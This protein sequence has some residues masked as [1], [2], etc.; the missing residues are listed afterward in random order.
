MEE[1][2]LGK[3]TDYPKTYCPQILTAVPRALNRDSYGIDNSLFTGFDSWH[4]YEVSFLLDSGMPVAGVLK[5]TYPSDTVCIVESKSLKLY[6]G[7]F[8][9]HKLGT[10]RQAG[11]QLLVECIVTDLSRLLQTEVKASFFLQPPSH[12]PFDFNGY[13]LLEEE[14]AENTR[15]S[16][17]QEHPA[18]LSEETE[19]KGEKKICSHLLKSNCKI[20]GQPDWGSI[21]IRIK[22][23]NLPADQSL[24]RYVVSLR[25]EN[26]FHEEICEMVYKR[27]YDLFHPEILAVTCLYT[28]R[29]GIDICPS[30]A[31]HPEYL[32]S[33]LGQVETLTLQEFRQ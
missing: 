31:N 24:L 28:R 16:I 29:G 20:T 19:G 6:L 27:L 5:I 4:A 11:I 30:R 10:T 17:Y 22:A 1:L 2:L 26:H 33:H 18:Y 32:P 14:V 15:F 7:S 3:Q 8:N 25:N 13:K 23:A 21:F 12:S 9:M